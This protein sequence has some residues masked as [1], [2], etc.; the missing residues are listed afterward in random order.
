MK[1]AVLY[2]NEDIRYVDVETPKPKKGEV[3]VKVHECGIC[4]SDVPRVLANGAHYYPI[5]LGHEFSGEVVELGEGVTKVKVGD[6]VSGVPLVPCMNCPDC[7]NGNYSLCKNYTF[8]GSRIQGAYAE[9]VAMPEANVVKF[10]K[11]VSYECGA[12]F[13]PSTV[14]L[15]GI[16]VSNFKKDT[17]VAILGGGTIGLLTMQWVNI[18]GCKSVTV[19]D[20]NDERLELAK[21]LGATYTINTITSDPVEETKKLFPRGFDF[22]FETCGSVPTEKLSFKVAGNKSTICLIGTPTKD[23]TFTP[24]E[25]EDIN[26]KEFILTGSWMSYSKPFPGKEWEMTSEYFSKGLLKI[27][28]SFIYKRYPL[29]NA[30]DAFQEFKNPKNVKGKI[31]LVIDENN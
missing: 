18:L 8:I 22:V 16:F 29:K 5:I 14:A 1:A 6:R 15:H 12:F 17:N 27:D 24:R 26:R 9:Y 20:I 23:I 10:D 4:G 7:N 13:E 31:L 30:Y 3:L 25:F 28:G 19:Y 11:N 2:K 21:E